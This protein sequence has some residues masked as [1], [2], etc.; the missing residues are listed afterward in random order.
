MTE[1]L[2]CLQNLD[3]SFGG[4]QVCSDISFTV[5]PG[6]LHALIGP[7]GAGK[8]TLLNLITG[9]LPVSGGV[10]LFKGRDITRFSVPA[11]A[12]LGMARSFQITSLFAGFTVQENIALAVQANEGSSY[13]F[14]QQASASPAL[15]QPA[16]EIMSRLGLAKRAGMR[17]SHLA[18]GEQ[19][20]LE[21]GMA[22]ATT[23]E[24]L[25]LDEPMAGLGPGSSR[26][27]AEMIKTLKGGVTIVLVEHDMEAVFS[28]ADRITVLD[29]GRVVATGTPEEIRNNPVVQD[30]YLGT[31]CLI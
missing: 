16:R 11:R 10:L 1:S 14:W 24:L 4:L 26:D 6:E 5:S 13:R 27:L 30:V 15:Q 22:L 3:K 17:A 23:P 21:I 9:L 2:L 18:H 28:L 20:L 29:Q 7:N 19:R 8:T 12:R 31:A 25:L